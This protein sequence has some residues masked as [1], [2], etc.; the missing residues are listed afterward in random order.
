VVFFQNPDDRLLF[1]RRGLVPPDKVELLPGSGIDLAE[2]SPRPAPSG[3]RFAFLMIA[4]LIRDK[5]IL[6]Y[7]EAARSLRARGIDADFRV[8][9]FLDDGNPTSV[10]AAEL[11]RWTEEGTISVL[12]RRDDVREE[13]ARAGCVVLPSYR[14]G[15]PRTL[16]EAAAMGRPVI[17][18]DVP[19]C[20]EVVEDGQTGLLCRA[21][22]SR[23]LAEKM[24]L[25]LGMAPAER[26]RLG[27]NGRAKMEREF[28]EQIVVDRYLG[29]LRKVTA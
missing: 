15:T 24:E 14:E 25:L 17:T 10:K 19:G 11:E 6:E 21:G 26:E 22:D 9:G 13:I 28:G 7:V 29:A 2:F 4:R 1:I 5:G 20:R 3:D 16:L 27:R 23:D 12:G 18:T 8:V